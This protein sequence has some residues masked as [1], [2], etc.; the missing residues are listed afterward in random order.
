MEFRFKNQ[1]QNPQQEVVFEKEQEVSTSKF[2][3]KV[4][5]YM[6]IGLLIT[7]VVSFAWALIVAKIYSDGNG[8]LT[9]EGATV[10]LATGIICLIGS[11]IV[12]VINSFITLGTKAKTAPWI[13]F[14]IYAIFI[15]GAFS[16]ILLAGIN[17]TVIAEAFGITALAFG[18]MFLVGYFSKKNLNW[19]ALVALGLGISVLLTSLFW[20]VFYLISPKTGLLIDYL[21]SLAIIAIAM[22]FVAIDSY[23]IKQIAKRGEANNN[24]ALYCA[25]NMYCDFLMLFMRILW[26]LLKAKRD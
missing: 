5:G 4:F 21:I 15:G 22:I 16:L 24:L 25:F 17:L 18:S 23:N 8:G 2:L 12:S 11:L 3:G 13:G 20:G 19:L 26:I 14:I 9:E 6:F 1:Q 10:A 7:A